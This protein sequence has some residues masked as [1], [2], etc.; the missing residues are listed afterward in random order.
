MDF[1]PTLGDSV[2]LTDGSEMTPAVGF[3]ELGG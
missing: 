2:Y 1:G 3:G